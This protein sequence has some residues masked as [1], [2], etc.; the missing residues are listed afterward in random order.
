MGYQGVGGG[1]RA[2]ILACLCC[3]A[4]HSVRSI[5][6]NTP[7]I[8]TH[9]HLTALHTA[10][11]LLLH[12]LWQAPMSPSFQQ[13]NGGPAQSAQFE[14]YLQ[15]QI[16]GQQQRG[17][18]GPNAGMMMMMPSSPAQYGLG[19]MPNQV[20]SAVQCSSRGRLPPPCFNCNVA[21]S[22]RHGHRAEAW[23]ARARFWR[24]PSELGPGR[25]ATP[26]ALTGF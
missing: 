6:Q 1:G 15:M 12:F 7:V 18:Q 9:Y 2:L 16:L 24:S 19:M 26:A 22:I 20:S 10:L 17:V 13:L 4:V 25:R 23:S 21:P 11:L 5:L 14:Q 8:C 3:V